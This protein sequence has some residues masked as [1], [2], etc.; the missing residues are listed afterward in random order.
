[1]TR[2][3][4]SQMKAGFR[5]LVAST[6]AVSLLSSQHSFAQSRTPGKLNNQGSQSSNPYN[7]AETEIPADLYPVC[8]LLDRIMSSSQLSVFQASIAIRS[9][10]GESC[11]EVLGNTP[12]CSLVSNLPDVGKEDSFLVWALQVSSASSPNLNAYA[13][14]GNNSIVL[15]RN[16]DDALGNNVEAKA[17]VIAHELAHLDKDHTKLRRQRIAELNGTA[18][19]K[20]VGAVR[21][22]HRAQTSQNFWGAVLAG[23]S[24]GLRNYGAAN[25]MIMQQS[26]DS[27]LGGVAYASIMQ[28]A[29]QE[30][31]QVVSVLSQMNGLSATMVQRT[32]KD[33]S[34]YLREVSEQ[35][36]S[37]SRIHE[38]EADQL[39]VGYLANAGI[40]PRGCIDMVTALHR[41]NPRP[42]SSPFDS[43]P[44][45]KDRL[46]KVHNA[47]AASEGTYRQAK[48]R[49]VN[50]QALEYR[51]DDR[52]EKVTLY[53]R[54]AQVPRAT[55]TIGNSEA[56]KR[57]LGD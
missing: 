42:I 12:L 28:S 1:M 14:S 53:S 44:G 16:L 40:N 25:S 46:T 36:A 56:V 26:T 51:Y 45:E 41:G 7:K 38:H 29:K 10:D 9:V 15:K 20:I 24:S 50:P 8:R 33:V 27:A 32:M 52:Y 37:L 23:V 31:P 2:N 21:N 47:V 4:T 43:H 49:L 35:A 48:T 5:A 30:A 34:A 13:M 54:G 57:L 55:R 3:N 39:A 11:K 18:A 19:V 22:A 17:C 6:V